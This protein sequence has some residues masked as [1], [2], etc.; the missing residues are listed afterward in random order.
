M[1]SAA[2]SSAPGRWWSVISTS[3]PRARAAATPATLEMPLSTVTMSDGA[4]SG[5][6]PD[7]LR[8][9]PVA[10]LEPVRHQEIDRR[11]SPGAQAAHDERRAGRAVG[12]EIADDEDAPL[13]MLEDER[14]RRF[15]AVERAH[16][17]QPVERE[18]ELLAVAHAARRIGAPQHRMQARVRDRHWQ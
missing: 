17:H 18:R 15:D 10:E 6:E 14:D 1:T 11:E 12:V 3:M 5:R 2:G 13:A 9:E 16:R 7:D 8:R 4:R